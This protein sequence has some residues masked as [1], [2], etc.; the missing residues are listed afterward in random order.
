MP[1][2]TATPNKAIKPTPADI[3]KG[4]PLINK[5]N[6]PPIA[7]KGMAENMSKVSVKEPNVMNNRA[8]IIKSAIGTIIINRCFAS[9]RF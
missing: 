4:I 5:A 8:R 7:A 9:I 3:L 1:F 2:K 6:T